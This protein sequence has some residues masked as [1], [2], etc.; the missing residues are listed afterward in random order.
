MKDSF[1]K[2]IKDLD[3]FSKGDKLILAISGGADSVALACLLKDTGYNFV[4]A[5]CNFKLR[6]NESDND[7]VFV[8]NLAEKMELE[9]YVKSL[10]T[11]SYSKKN[12]ISLQ[13]A[14]RELRYCWFEELRKEI[15]AKYILVAQHKDDNL[16]TFFINL[17]RGSGIKGLLGIKSKRDKIVRPLLI[18][19]RK[20]IENYL[21]IKKQ[22]FRNDS[23]NSDVKYLRNNIRHHLI[24]LIK[25]MNPSFENTLSQEVDF[26]NEIYNVFMTN[27]ENI[28]EE[29]VEMTEKGCEIDKSKLLSIQNNKIFLRE[30]ITPF[31]FSQC[32]KILE[33]C[34]SISGKL[35]FSHTHKLLVDRKKLIITEIKKEKNLFIELEEFD[36]LTYPI[37]LRFRNSDQKQFNTNK[38]TV[39]LDKKK[40][41][42]PLTLRK[43]KQGD[44]FY[45]L[46]MNGKKRLSDYFI[47][48]KFTQFDKEEC[49]LLCSGEDIVWIIGHRMDD[50]F[51][52]TDDTKKVY[53]AELFKEI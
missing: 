51:K 46:G 14:A 52:I 8:K 45:P 41:I 39:F 35:F 9:C 48:N 10:N 23:S 47:D 50:R 3:L 38:N 33:S 20:Q 43:W 44:F 29:L 15:D 16:E 53:I 5:H 34:R 26:L 19:S 2:N 25:D 49:Y 27:F 40:L 17:I 28:K 24:P 30:I 7:E 42:F 31:G 37:S 13:M 12:K 36:N 1:L 22:K 4:L 32:D 11:E 6:G 21:S 18:F